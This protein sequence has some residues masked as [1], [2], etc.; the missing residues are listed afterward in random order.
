MAKLLIDREII[1]NGNQLIS[2][3]NGT[4]KE[5]INSYNTPDVILFSHSGKQ[6]ESFNSIFQKDLKKN[7]IAIL[8]GFQK[9]TFS[10]ESLE[11]SNNI[12]ALSEYHLDSWV[13]LYK[14]I[15]YYE[16]IHNIV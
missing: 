13:A 2:E 16:I 7:S 8:G 1:D 6:L 14:I 9:G 15:I 11:L 12:K 3:Y 4:L 5:L 10:K